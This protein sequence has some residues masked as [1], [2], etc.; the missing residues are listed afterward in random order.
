M[1]KVKIAISLDNALLDSIDNYIK[2]ANIPSRSHAINMLLKKVIKYNPI[3]QAILLIREQDQRYLF[4]KFGDITLIEHNIN[5][6]SSNGINEIYLITKTNKVLY[7][8]LANLKSNAKIEV[9]DEKSNSGTASALLLI[10]D[11]LRNNFIL[12]NADT[13][14]DFNLKNMIKEH[15]RDNQ[16]VTLGLITSNSSHGQNVNYIVLDG[17]MI[18]D[19]RNQSFQ[20]N[21]IINAGVYILNRE[22]FNFYTNKTHSLDKDL[23]PMLIS[24]KRVQGIFTFGRFIHAPDKF[25]KMSLSEMVDRLSIVRLKLER[26]KEDSLKVEYETY[27]NAIEGYKRSGVKIKSK[28]INDLYKINGKM[29]DLEF[30]IRSGKEGKLGL[31]EVGRRAI[32]IRDLNKQRITIKNEIAE[33]TGLGFKEIK[34]D[35]ASQ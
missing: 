33:E 29:W 2:S 22:I 34:I 16:L 24:T 12:M 10:K 27:K 31:E 23:I 9:I 25:V 19:M 6:L 14:N 30:D 4:E 32:A 8:S 20:G 11:K 1:K 7:N 15:I 3:S 18:V 28:W 26:L 17:K 21:N 35:H 5:F 13:F